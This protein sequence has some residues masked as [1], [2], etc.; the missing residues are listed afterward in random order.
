MA[1]RFRP[2]SAG[3][4][5]QWIAAEL[6]NSGAVCGVPRELFFVPATDDAL[7]LEVH[8]RRRGTPIGV[9]A[10]PHTQLAQNIVVAWLCGARTIELK[11][12]QTRDVLSIAK[13][14]IDMTDEGYNTEWSQE[15]SVEASL[16]QYLAAWVLIHGLHRRL[17]WPGS[18]P[19]VAF[20]ISVGYDLDG[21]RKPNMEWFLE[22]IVDAGDRL[23][24]CLDEV[25]RWLPEVADIDIPNRLAHSCTLSTLHGC[26]PG[27]IGAV[28]EHLIAGWG[29]DTAVKLNPTLLGYET[30]RSI[31]VDELGWTRVEPDRSAFD[32]DLGY[33]DAIDL[34][35]RLHDS[36]AG[37]ERVFGVKVC[38]T[39][40]V[41]NRRPTLAAGG[42]TA[43]LSGRPLHAL[44]VELARRLTADI[45]DGLPIS[46]S[47]GADPFNTPELLAAR[48]RPV[49]VCSDLLR[50]GGYLRLG[51]YFDEIR[52]AL[53]RFGAADLDDLVVARAGPNVPSEMAARHN[54]RRWADRLRADPELACASYHRTETKTGRSLGLFDC[55]DAPCIEACGVSQRVPDYMRAVAVGDIGRAA[56]V[57]ARDNPL[58]S[59]LGRACHHPCERV[60]IRTHLDQPVAIREIK[61]FVTDAIQPSIQAPPELG[62]EPTV[63]I[64]GAG[65]CGLAVAVELARAGARSTIFEARDTGGGM[66]SA[67]IPGYRAAPSVVRRDLAAI[68][69]LGIPVEVGVEIGRDVT[70]D[71]LLGGRFDAVVV[72]VGAQ[73]G[74][75]LGLPGEDADGVIDGLDLLRA[76]G[77]G[78]HPDL[79]SRVA[80]IGGGDVAVDCARSA[81]RLTDG[82]VTIF[83]RRTVDQMPA[84]PEEIRELRAEGVEIR[85]LVSPSRLIV[86]RHRLRELE[87]S[88]MAL[89]EDDESGRPRPVKVGRDSVRFDVDSVIVA[90]GQQ[91]DLGVFGDLA[92]ELAPSGFVAVDPETLETSIHGIFVGGDLRDPGPATI[93]D[94]CGD[95]RRIARAILRRAGRQISERP[96][97][98]VAP[99]DPV[100]LLGRRSR[101]VPRVVAPRRTAGIDEG[102]VE[103]VLTLDREAAEI[104]AGRCLD[105]DL[106][107]ATC[108]GVCPNRAI[109]SY[110]APRWRAVLRAVDNDNPDELFEITQE[111]QVAVVADLCNECG[112]C[113][114]F[115][116]TV[117]RPWRDKPRLALSRTDFEA[118]TDNAFMLLRADN[119]PAIQG[120]FAGR[121]F[122]LADGTELE[123]RGPAFAVRL[124][125]ESLQIV[126]S[127][128]AA[129]EATHS[130][131]VAAVMWTLLRGIT[132]SLPHFPLVEARPEWLLD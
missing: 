122:Q 55:V 123:Y 68:A 47:G 70:L 53:E 84:R 102:F 37:R 103:D 57:I 8:G 106:M 90:V 25:G 22:H 13:P 98:V 46:F 83:Y 76:I 80:V 1:D 33:R 9:A 29:F 107:C 54:L 5:A 89:G 48:L 56:T 115:C 59:I 96:R 77:H 35:R 43:Y 49:T 104:E 72:A 67:T 126:G 94:A 21:L 3:R 62:A 124:D 118:E 60:C 14:C 131:R 30:A 44:A 50:P 34:A 65:P 64:I 78:D 38:N 85:E 132:A 119:R 6:A 97:V 18:S 10:G 27:E 95:G 32:I 113:A 36:A 88:I 40:P 20:D 12:V 112:N 7:A 51:Q 66:V 105:C 63:A 117:G 108:V 111:P 71:Q 75:R 69:E 101:R 93:V 58:P 79:G 82:E 42:A 116:P 73:R 16:D 110:L 19:D 41:V 121:T 23:D 109:F 39:L 26:P 74:L 91:A 24:R 81:R 15:L 128:S 52:S 2:L 31:L 120:R 127:S 92:V 86:D 125:P 130:L 61:R 11:T 17:G 45:G 129:P 114:T 100:D 28:V 4:L 99:S 87:C